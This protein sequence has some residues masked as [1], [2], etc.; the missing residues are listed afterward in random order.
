MSVH[1]HCYNAFLIYMP[2]YAY[3]Q[4][5]VFIKTFCSYL[6]FVLFGFGPATYTKAIARL[7]AIRISGGYYVTASYGKSNVMCMIMS[8][9]QYVLNRWQEQWICIFIWCIHCRWRD[10]S[11]WI[12]SQKTVTFQ[13]TYFHM[14][15]WCWYEQNWKPLVYE[16]CCY[17]S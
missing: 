1:W 15:A 4:F 7:G 14:R 5:T 3:L 10:A 8:F 9:S 16:W 13:V 17:V 12:S 6:Q 11:W 2:K